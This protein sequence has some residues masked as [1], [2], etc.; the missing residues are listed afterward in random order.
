VVCG[1]HYPSDAIGSRESAGIVVGNMLASPRFQE[2]FAAAKAEVR[3]AL[4]L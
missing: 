3:K 1:D 4:G 2:K